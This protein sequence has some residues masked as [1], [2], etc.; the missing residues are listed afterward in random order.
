MH[1]SHM[2]GTTSAQTIRQNLV[3]IALKYLLPQLLNQILAGLCGGVTN[4]PYQ[5]GNEQCVV[6]AWSGWEPDVNLTTLFVNLDK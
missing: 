5:Q 6:D 4:H 2:S 1:I 3:Y